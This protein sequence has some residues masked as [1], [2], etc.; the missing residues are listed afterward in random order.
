MTTEIDTELDLNEQLLQRRHKLAALRSKGNAFPN[1][2]RPSNLSADINA[3]HA[4]KDNSV[5]ET[6]HNAVQIAG[7]IMMR[8]LMGKASFVHVQDRTGKIQLYVRQEDL[9]AGNYE[10]F[11]DWDIGDIIGASGVL[12]KTKTGELSVKVKEIRLLTKSLHPLP[13]KWHGL[14]DQ[15]TRYRQ[16]YLD[17]IVN[18]KSRQVFQTRIKVIQIIR[19]FF[20]SKDYLEVETVIF[21]HLA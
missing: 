20:N 19:D 17:L 10:E 6:E 5:L 8:R 14:S 4:N 9:L 7:R 1:D 12:F 16:R 3:A 21:A 2:F 15:E 11:K 13:D 18:E